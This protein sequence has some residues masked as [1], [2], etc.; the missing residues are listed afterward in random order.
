LL[1]SA[2]DCDLEW[3]D[4]LG[5]LIILI[6]LLYLGLSYYYIFKKFFGRWIYKSI[7][8][9]ISEKWSRLMAKRWTELL[10]KWFCFFIIK[11]QI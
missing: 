5:M 9:P 4:G 7:M 3:C 11:K 8:E 10:L 1:F 6:A 2:G